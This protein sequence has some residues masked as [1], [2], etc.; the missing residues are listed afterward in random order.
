MGKAPDDYKEETNFEDNDA[1]KKDAAEEEKKVGYRIGSFV[2]KL[3]IYFSKPY[4][5]IPYL[6]KLH[7]FLIKL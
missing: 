6:L 2:Q 5:Y 1:K 7:R 4:L 3:K